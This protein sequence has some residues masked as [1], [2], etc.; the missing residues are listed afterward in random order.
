MIGLEWGYFREMKFCMK[1]VYKKWKLP[2]KWRQPQK[3]KLSQNWRW[4]QN[5]DDI[6]NEDDLNTQYT[7]LV[8]LVYLSC[9]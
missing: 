9:F 8:V 2:Q 1:V 5:E 3:L 6:K 7:S 4:P